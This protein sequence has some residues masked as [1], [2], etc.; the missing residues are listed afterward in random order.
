MIKV[1]HLIVFIICIISF[2]A[3]QNYYQRKITYIIDEEFGIPYFKNEDLI[4]KIKN[5]DI[6]KDDDTIVNAD[7]YELLNKRKK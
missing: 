3:Y 1:S 7:I 6:D 2:F 4:L 5:Q